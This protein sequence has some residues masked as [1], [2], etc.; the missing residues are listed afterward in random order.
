VSGKDHRDVLKKAKR[1]GARIE[2]RK[3]GHIRVWLPDGSYVTTAQSPSD[4]YAGRQLARDLKR[5]GFDVG[6][7]K[8]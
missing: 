8:R 6:R 3:S 1:M 2:Q 4:N 7:G 5:R